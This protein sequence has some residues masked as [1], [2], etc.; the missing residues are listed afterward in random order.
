[1]DLKKILFSFLLVCSIGVG[2]VFAQSSAELKKQ[3]ER[4]DAEIAELMKIVRAKT[5]EKL[6]SQKEV[7][8]L[9][10]QLSLREDK[11]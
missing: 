7:N 4:I 8:A 6:L 5:Q 1:M 9:S 11:I 10:R 3:R 2:G